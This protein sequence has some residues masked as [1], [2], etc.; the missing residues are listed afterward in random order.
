MD[1]PVDADAPAILL[2]RRQKV[3]TVR[4]QTVW[5]LTSYIVNS[6]KIP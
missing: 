3:A 2:K 6:F 1:F 4:R 5:T